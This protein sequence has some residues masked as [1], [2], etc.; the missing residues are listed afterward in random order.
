MSCWYSWFELLVKND[1]F[2]KDMSCTINLQFLLNCKSYMLKCDIALRVVYNDITSAYFI[3]EKCVFIKVNFYFGRSLIY[4]APCCYPIIRY[5]IDILFEIKSK[6]S[7]DEN[8]FVLH[9]IFWTLSLEL[10]FYSVFHMSFGFLFNMRI[11]I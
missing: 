2:S 10:N 5:L 4:T 9:I 8:L 6:F 7:N 11:S 1:F 3:R